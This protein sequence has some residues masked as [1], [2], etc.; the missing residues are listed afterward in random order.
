MRIPLN[1]RRAIDK[2]RLLIMSLDTGDTLAMM[3]DP[4]GFS[5]QLYHRVEPMI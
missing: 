1:Y 4:W 2:G 5:I 3:R